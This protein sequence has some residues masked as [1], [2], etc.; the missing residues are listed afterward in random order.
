MVQG[1]GYR[2]YTLAAAEKLRVSGSLS[3]LSDAGE[4]RFG[5]GKRQGDDTKSEGSAVNDVVSAKERCA[6][7]PA[8]GH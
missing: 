4:E 8:P 3:A 1:V 7:S 6:N 2:Y 5:E